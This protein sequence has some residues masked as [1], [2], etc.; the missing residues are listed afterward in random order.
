[1]SDKTTNKFLGK[2]HPLKKYMTRFK[3]TSKAVSEGTGLTAA[4]IRNVYRTGLAQGPTIIK[5]HKYTRIRKDILMFPELT[6]MFDVSK[7]RA[8]KASIIN[9]DTSV[10]C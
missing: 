3:L 6:P 10:N 9:I 4:C 8:P 7:C 5:L 2:N 1:M